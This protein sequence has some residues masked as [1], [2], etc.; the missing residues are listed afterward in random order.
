MNDAMNLYVFQQ[1]QELFALPEFADHP[2]V[3]SLQLSSSQLKAGHQMPSLESRRATT[4]PGT[5]PQS[6]HALSKSH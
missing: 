4:L 5:S 1:T 3:Q 2:G 6:V